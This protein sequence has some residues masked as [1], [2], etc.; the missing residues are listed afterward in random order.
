MLLVAMLLVSVPALYSTQAQD[1]EDASQ[2]NDAAL[3]SN[4]QRIDLL[5][6]NGFV[7]FYGI[8]GGQISVIENAMSVD[9]LLQQSVTS[10]AFEEGGE[11]GD[12]ISTYVVQSGD[13]LSTIA[14]KFG[15]SQNTIRWA[16][17]I[18][19]KGVIRVGQELVILPVSGIQ[20][21]VAKGD[22]PSDIAKKYE[23]DVEELLAYNGLYINEILE[24]GEVITVP[25]GTIQEVVAVAPAKKSSVRSTGKKVSDLT[26][27]AWTN[28]R[29][30]YRNGVFTSALRNTGGV[31]ADGYYTKPVVGYP[32]SRGLHGNNGIDW[33]APKG[34]SVVA[35]A[36]GTVSVAR[37]GGWNGGYGKYVIIKHGNGTQ[38]VYSHLSSVSVYAGQSVVSGQLI[39]RVGTTGNSTGN[40]LHFEVRG[41][42][43]PWR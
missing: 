39:G 23:A 22:T 2:K 17:D 38:T 32:R 42:K 15:V 26:A 29:T 10:T 14:E 9:V 43:N 21:T 13:T 37:S 34:T 20:H 36:G 18:S 40:H 19:R 24:I 6:S 27:K 12:L 1:N 41:A 30:V 28:T 4:T 16:N 5:T 8:G 3:G 33:A 7:D 35:A 31:N 25:N 11:N